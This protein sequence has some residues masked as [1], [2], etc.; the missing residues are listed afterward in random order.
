MSALA[1]VGF[2]GYAIVLLLG[3][4]VGA[5]GAEREMFLLFDLKVE[6]LDESRAAFMH[7][8]RFLRAT[9]AG[10][11]LLLLML[12]KEIFTQRKFNAAFLG[13]LAL[14]PAARTASLWLDG[15]PGL[16]H[17]TFMVLAYAVL[18]VFAAHSWQTLWRPSVWRKKKGDG[19]DDEPNQLEKGDTAPIDT[20]ALARELDA[21]ERND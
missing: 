14:V 3:G 4:I 12:R 9:E 11:G 15:W 21:L 13:L 19:T 7:Q 1:K 5:V 6:E 2:W 18:G 10:A 16:A 17:V 8:Y 20:D